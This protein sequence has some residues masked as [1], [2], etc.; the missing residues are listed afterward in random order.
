MKKNEEEEERKKGR[1]KE[2][3]ERKERKKERKERKEK[4]I[5]GEK[6]YYLTCYC[7]YAYLRCCVSHSTINAIVTFHNIYW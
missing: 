7:S 5:K 4:K 2:G 3:K 6:N 1:K